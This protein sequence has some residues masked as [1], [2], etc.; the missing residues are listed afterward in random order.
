MKESEGRV[1]K[2]IK[3]GRKKDAPA[4]EQSVSPHLHL[5]GQWWHLH[6]EVKGETR[7]STPPAWWVGGE[8]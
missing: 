4:G 3:V 2:G 8:I 5:P 6:S 7:K 1:G